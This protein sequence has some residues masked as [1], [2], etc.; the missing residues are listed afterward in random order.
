VTSARPAPTPRAAQLFLPR[1]RERGTPST[2]APDGRPEV[3]VRSATSADVRAMSRL[4]VEHLPVGLF[5]ALGARFVAR[6]HQAHIDSSHGVALVSY[7]PGEDGHPVTGFL[8]GSVDRAS[9]RIDLLGRHRRDLLLHSAGALLLRPRV[10]ARFLRTR[11][12]A[13]LRRLRRRPGGTDRPPGPAVAELTAIAVAPA[14]HRRGAGRALTEEFL[15]ACARAGATRAELVADDDAGGFYERI[16]WRCGRSATTRDG[17]SLRRFSI[18][19][20]D[21]GPR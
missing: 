6:W 2:A 18:D 13:Y 8:V 20:R 19:L 15:R 14:R 1:P 4:H 7:H 21:E 10:L 5:P 16:G 3:V 17:A 11:S 9:F 12:S